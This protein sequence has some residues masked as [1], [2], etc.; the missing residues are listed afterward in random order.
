M[1]TLYPNNS[2]IIYVA[3]LMTCYNRIAKT[4]EC[5]N[6]SY[7]S[8]IPDNIKFTI[9]LVDDNSPDQTGKIVKE[10]YSDIVVIQ[11]TGSLYWNRCMR[12]AWENACIAYDYDFYLWLNDDTIIEP[13]AFNIIFS[14]YFNLLNT[15]I[16]AI[17]TSVC[18][19]IDPTEIT[20]GGRNEQ[21]ESIVP[22]GDP[23]SCKYINGNFTLISKVIFHK[24]GNLSSKYTHS[25]GD[26]DYGLRAIKSGF[27]CY[28]TSSSLA[29]CIIDHISRKPDYFNLD[30]SF[31]KRLR[32]LFFPQSRF[33]DSI[34]FSF[35]D[36]GFVRTI[37]TIISTIILMLFP[38]S[39]K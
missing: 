39:D 15:G 35:E 8:K 20:Y 31:W 30:F 11:G 25:G 29:I 16:E 33:I 10:R 1:K 5:L 28:I 38:N 18:H 32:I 7:K 27:K 12:L 22:N 13:D 26:Y 6:N 17:I 23:Q 3:I 14:D 24:V 34:M 9:Y 37:R 19:G 21:Y 36:N 4:L 2:T